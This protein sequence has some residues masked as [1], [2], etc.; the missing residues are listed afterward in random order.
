MLVSKWISKFDL[1]PPTWCWTLQLLLAQ[2][3][4]SIYFSVA[5]HYW[6]DSVCESKTI[7]TF[8]GSG[9]PYNTICLLPL[10]DPAI[11]FPAQP[12]HSQHVSRAAGDLWA[13]GQ[14]SLH[15][16]LPP[17][18]HLP[19]HH[20]RLWP[21][22]CCVTVALLHPPH[23]HYH[24]HH[25]DLTKCFREHKR[26]VFVHETWIFFQVHTCEQSCQHFLVLHMYEKANLHLCSFQFVSRLDFIFLFSW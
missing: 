5:M 17:E 10:P 12:L 18:C 8:Q 23:N 2:S 15:P 19:G 22:P 11:L 21:G 26:N 16:G 24:H 3:H 7:W 9:Q 13:L 6:M 14:Q 25:H 20:L 4:F 1:L